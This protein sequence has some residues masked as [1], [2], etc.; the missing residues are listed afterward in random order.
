M[1]VKANPPDG[2][3]I[4]DVAGVVFRD[5]PTSLF[6]LASL[7]IGSGF[8]VIFAYQFL[9]LSDLGDT[10]IIMGLATLF[11]CLTEVPVFYMSDALIKPLGLIRSLEL[12]IFL[13][14]VRLLWYGYMTTA[15]QTLYVEWT[16]GVSV[17]I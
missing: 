17:L 9:L 11:T 16:H 15:S 4:W 1:Q 7:L 3:S 2:G 14:T 10:G 6:F 12:C 5:V 8:G 13:A